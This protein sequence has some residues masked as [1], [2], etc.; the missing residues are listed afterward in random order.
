MH[1]KAL[2]FGD[3]PIAAKILQ[4]TSPKEQKSL[5]RKVKNFKESTWSLHRS[6]IVEEGSYLKFK[7]GADKGQLESKG[8]TL[9]ARLL[10]TGERELVEASPMDRVWG[11][12]FTER[13]AEERRGEWGLN[14]LGK[15]LAKARERLRTE[16]EAEKKQSPGEVKKT[17]EEGK[18]SKFDDG[19]EGS[20][21]N[22]KKCVGENV[23]GTVGEAE[24]EAEEEEE[25]PK[26]RT[27]RGKKA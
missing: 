19:V 5:G 13:W 23:P 7:Y 11:I 22:E 10:Q 8:L 18:G 1:Q 15:A 14:L 6:R 4:T 27:R 12:G 20:D 9:K 21:A 25:R 3:A 24:A 17:G 2:L 16:E 26:K